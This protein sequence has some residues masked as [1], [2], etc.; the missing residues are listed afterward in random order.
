MK[1]R[2]D[3]VASKWGFREEPPR[4]MHSGSGPQEFAREGAPLKRV[5]D[6]IAS[7]LGLV[8]L[9]PIFLIIACLVKGTSAGPVFFRQERV[10]W[11]GRRFRIFK[12]STMVNGAHRKGRLITVGGDQRVTTCGIILRRFKLDELPQLLNV[13]RGEMSLVGPRPE[14]PEYV[15]AFAAEFQPILE[16]KPGITHRAAILFRDEEMLLAASDDPEAY[17]VQTLMPRKL[18]LYARDLDR[19]G[20][21]EDVRTIVDTIFSVARFHSPRRDAWASALSQPV[22]LRAR[23]AMAGATTQEAV[24]SSVR[25]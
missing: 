2:E 25:H 7:L 16:Q 3:R 20:F 17:Y 5:F 18:Q 19:D 23:R 21:L 24:S 11:H 6:F 13:L 4:S 22:P 1:L 10:G 8:L 14:V 9:A 15:E 12:F